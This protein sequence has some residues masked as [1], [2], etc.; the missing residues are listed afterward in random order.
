MG[1]VM[2]TYRSARQAL[3]DGRH[4]VHTWLRMRSIR[5]T[6]IARLRSVCILLGP[7]RNLSTLTASTLHLHPNCQALNHAGRR[8]LSHDRR[9]FLADYSARKFKAFCRFALAAS[10]GG[11]RGRYGGS[12]NLSHAFERPAMKTVYAKRYPG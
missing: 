9:N 3:C 2:R 6:D 5:E 11:Q 12:I 8:V 4:D 10:Q 1:I 7:Y